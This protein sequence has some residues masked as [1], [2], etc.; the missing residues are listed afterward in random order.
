MPNEG[1]TLERRLFSL[2]KRLHVLFRKGRINH[3]I[4]LQEM[5][6]KDGVVERISKVGGRHNQGEIFDVQCI[7]CGKNGHEENTC[8]IMWEKIS[9]E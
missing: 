6:I 2:L 4:V 3:M 1:K 9:E 5:E 8:R 7:D